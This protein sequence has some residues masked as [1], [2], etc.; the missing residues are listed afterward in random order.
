MQ[1][2]GVKMHPRVAIWLLSVFQLA[3]LG[4]VL[5]LYVKASRP[6]YYKWDEKLVSHATQAAATHF[7]TTEEE[8]RRHTF[9][10]TM[11]VDRQTCVELRRKRDDLFGYLACYQD[12]SG[13]VIYERVIGVPFGPRR[14]FPPLW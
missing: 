8:I 1:R 3:A 5:V 9:P 6:L 4:T 13:E 12:G 10:I 2:V 7:R 11:R 14:F